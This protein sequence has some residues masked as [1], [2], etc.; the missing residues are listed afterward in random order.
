M[1]VAFLLKILAVFTVLVILIRLRLKIGYTFLATTAVFMLLFF[2]G[3]GNMGKTVYKS[4]ISWETW[5]LLLSVYFILIIGEIMEFTGNVKSFIHSIIHGL[6]NKRLAATF[7]PAFIGL[8]PMPGGALFSAPMVKNTLDTED[9]KPYMLTYF[10]YWYRHIWEYFWPMYPEIILISSIF[11]VK[12]FDIVVH[13]WYF[14]IVA[15]FVGYLFTRKI[16]FR[17]YKPEKVKHFKKF[18]KSS[19]FVFFII[20][21][22]LGFRIDIVIV[23]VAT[24]LIYLIAYR[25]V[26]K[27]ILKIG[28]KSFDFNTVLLLIGIMIFKM[29]IKDSGFLTHL[30]D[31]GNYSRTMQ[32]G[33]LI[34][35][36]F[37][38]GIMTGIAVGFVGIAFP[39][40]SVIFIQNGVL[41]F[42]L[43]AL[44]FVSG[45]AGVLLSPFHLCLVLTKE[46]FKA[47]FVNIYKI[48]FPSVLILYI[49]SVSIIFILS[50]F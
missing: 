22:L 30:G 1:E 41:N 29:A 27:N 43:L 11:N 31:I 28:Q 21:F 10:N 42:H 13:Q 2:Y 12:I 50:V 3:W 16:K 15:I 37:I 49:L 38:M 8:I 20:I 5:K 26:R 18:I 6:R 19:W 39:L 23:L 32:Y 34:F 17:D 46:Y 47:K 25:D 48:L 33:L 4:L 14:T 24:I 44:S 40:L 45:F 7:L 9:T 36:P 35:L